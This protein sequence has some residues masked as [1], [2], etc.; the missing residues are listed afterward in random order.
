MIAY[1]ILHPGLKLRIL[2]GHAS[3]I[4]ICYSPTTPPDK[5]ALVPLK[6]HKK[7]GGVHT[8]MT[9]QDS[10]PALPPSTDLVSFYTADRVSVLL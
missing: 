4:I 2:T 7:A 6:L 9:T 5:L 3:T 8:K 1:A 10:K